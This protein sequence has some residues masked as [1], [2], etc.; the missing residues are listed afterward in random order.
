ME[1][2]FHPD[3]PTIMTGASAEFIS[4]LNI[5]PQFGVFQTK[6]ILDECVKFGV[7]TTNFLNKCVCCFFHLRLSNS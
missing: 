5:A 7:D 6:F 4:A 3:P 1:F 2:E